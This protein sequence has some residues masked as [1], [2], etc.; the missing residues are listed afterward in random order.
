MSVRTWTR[1]SIRGLIFV[2]VTVLKITLG[3]K[4]YQLQTETLPVGAKH[5]FSSL[6]RPALTSTQTPIQRLPEVISLGVKRALEVTL[7]T[8]THLVPRLSMSRSYT[9]SPLFD[10]IAVAGQL[11]YYIYIYIYIYMFV[12]EQVSDH[13]K[14]F[15]ENWRD[16]RFTQQ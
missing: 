5:F 15:N 9:P 1:T 8:A 11:Y 4:E 3:K 10:N 14:N 7:T 6:S 16:L 2:I 12:P 13:F